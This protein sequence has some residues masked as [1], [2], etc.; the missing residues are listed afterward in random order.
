MSE[1]LATVR[2]LRPRGRVLA[3]MEHSYLVPSI[4]T[5]KSKLGSVACKGDVAD[6]PYEIV[7]TMRTPAKLP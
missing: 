4:G 7:I 3:H 6:D 1:A 2:S 5:L